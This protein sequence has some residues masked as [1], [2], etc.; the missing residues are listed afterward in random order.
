[1]NPSTTRARPSV[2]TITTAA[3]TA[4]IMPCGRR[5]GGAEAR[6]AASSALMM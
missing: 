2:A 1:M 3:V 6:T 5:G 4:R